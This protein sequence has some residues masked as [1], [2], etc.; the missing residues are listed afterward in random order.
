MNALSPVRPTALRCREIGEADLGAVVDLLMRGFPGRRASYWTQGF[1]RMAALD[2]PAGYPRFGLIMESGRVPVGV[3]LTLYHLSGDA[4]E[5]V[6]CNLSSWYVVP[7]FRPYA[8]LLISIALKRRDVTYINISPAPPTWPI[9]E[10]QG[11]KRYAAG[12]F[13]AFPAL[14]PTSRG[15]SVAQF[16]SAANYAGLS[17]D[18]RQLLADHAAFGCLSLVCH[19]P[20]G[21]LPFIFTGF[22]IRAGRIRLPCARLLYCRDMADFIACVGA[23]GRFL[24]WRGIVA[25]LLDADG[26]IPGLRGFYTERLGRKYFRGAKPPRFGDLAYSE[27]AVFGS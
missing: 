4:V 13:V 16:S 1:A 22:S 7:A 11:F 15:V 25:V 2:V 10:A 18:E 20:G 6:R 21:D 3:I 27:L 23:L 9:V 5:S 19:T 17:D 8:S 14:E 26:T 24:L 12:Q